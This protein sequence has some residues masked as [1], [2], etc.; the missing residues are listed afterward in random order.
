MRVCSARYVPAFGRLGRRRS[1]PPD[2][3]ANGHPST[4]TGSPATTPRPRPAPHAESRRLQLP[5]ASRLLS[6]PLTL[7][8]GSLNTRV[9]CDFCLVWAPNKFNLVQKYTGSFRP[10]F[11]SHGAGQIVPICSSMRTK[12]SGVSPSDCRA[13]LT[14]HRAR[15]SSRRALR[16]TRSAAPPRNSN[17]NDRQGHRQGASPRLVPA[18]LTEAR[19]TERQ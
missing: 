1:G 2:E 4:R 8:A 17:N 12:I 18:S 13:Q 10:I 16:S 6:T 15:V 19:S 14:K 5:R 7:T 11:L 9:C 3:H